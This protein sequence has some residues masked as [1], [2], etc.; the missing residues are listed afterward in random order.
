MKVRII[1]TC[2]KKGGASIAA[3]RLNYSIYHF[4]KDFKVDMQVANYKKDMKNVIKPASKFISAWYLARRELGNLI[5]KAQISEN[6]VLHSTSL[7]RSTIHR[8]INNCDADIINLHWIQGEFISIKSISLIKKPLI[9][10]FHDLWPFLGSEHYPKDINDRRYIDGYN[11]FNRSKS[12]KGFDL[13]LLTWKTKKRFFRKPIQIVCNSNWL[14]D[15]VKNSALMHSWPVEIIPNPIPTK[16]YTPWPKKYSRTLFNLPLNKE[17]VLFGAIGGTEDSRKGWKFLKIAL[18]KLSFRKKNLHAVIFGQYEPKNK[19]DIGIPL[20]FIGELQDD[21]SLAML[22][23]AADVMIVPSMMETLS[24]TAAEAQ[25]CGVPV[26]AFNC[27]GLVDAV[28]DRKTGY[29]AKPFESDD[30]SFGI[31]WVLNRDNYKSLCLESR[32]RAERLWNEEIITMQ[33]E[34]IY[35]KVLGK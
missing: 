15:C 1:S 23:S 3:S 34:E 29:L 14:A 25:S 9:W 2:N 4:G 16:I 20:T 30:L 22:Y 18:K 8:D 31:E 6:K 13:D 33:Y 12:E 27:T 24:Q 26:V 11:K 21:Q 28:E 5:Q 7:L 35:K 19:P 32:K 10:T 17:L